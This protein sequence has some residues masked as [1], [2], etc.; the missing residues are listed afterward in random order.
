MI[1]L[2]WHGG[3]ADVHLK[4]ATSTLEGGGLS[5]PRSGCFTSGKDVV[6]IVQGLGGHELFVLLSVH[7]LSD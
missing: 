4:L 7:V 1:C 5:A 6:P 3:E 2:C